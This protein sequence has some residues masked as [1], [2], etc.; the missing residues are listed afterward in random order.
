MKDKPEIEK[1]TIT[2]DVMRING[3]Y[4]IGSYGI[5]ALVSEDAISVIAELEVQMNQKLKIKND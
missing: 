1:V 4:Y 2:L 5:M 3:R